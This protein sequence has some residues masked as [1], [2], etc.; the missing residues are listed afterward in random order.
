VTCESTAEPIKMGYL[1]DFRM[2]EGSPPEQHDP[3]GV[4]SHLVDRFGQD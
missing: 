4:T 3:D 1:F 2:P